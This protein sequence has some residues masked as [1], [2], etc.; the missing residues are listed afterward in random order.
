MS[1]SSDPRDVCLT[2]AWRLS[3]LKAEGRAVTFSV[4]TSIARQA[5][6]WNVQGGGTEEKPT[7]ARGPAAERPRAGSA[8]RRLRPP[9]HLLMPASWPMPCDT[10]LAEISLPCTWSRGRGTRCLGRTKTGY[11]CVLSPTGPPLPSYPRHRRTS[12]FFPRAIRAA[13]SPGDAP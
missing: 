7:T 6:I 8:E 12:W 9:R 5:L 2:P 4:H 11:A 10:L 1:T 13:G 3:E